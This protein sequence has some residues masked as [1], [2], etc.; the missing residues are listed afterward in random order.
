MTTRLLDVAGALVFDLPGGEDKRGRGVELFR[1]DRV[2]EALGRNF[3]PVQT[4]LLHNNEGTLR[5][6]HLAAGLR[7]GKLI[8]GV[9]GQIWD[10][11]FDFRPGSPTRGLYAGVELSGAHPESIYCPPGVAHGFVSL[12]S[13]SIVTLTVDVLFSGVP[14]YAIEAFDSELGI[15]WPVPE[16]ACVRSDRDMSAPAFRHAGVVGIQAE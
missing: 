8:T 5:G 12:A 10:V 15:P 6:L 2:T 3:V 13:N 9:A 14:E 1:E 11:L 16:S 7:Q 4:S